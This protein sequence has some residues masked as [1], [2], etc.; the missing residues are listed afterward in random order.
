[1][2]SNIEHSE[3]YNLKN[4]ISYA[5]G[6]VVSKTV[7]KNNAGN[8]SLFAFAKAQSLS[9]HTAPFDAMVYI[10]DG[11]AGITI[12]EKQLEL[13]EGDFTIMPANIPHALDAIE[14]FKMLLIMIKA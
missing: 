8:I 13:G 11:K 10:I 9:S 6:A 2:N 5:E 12:G 4:A 1:M 7:S 14:E 3:I